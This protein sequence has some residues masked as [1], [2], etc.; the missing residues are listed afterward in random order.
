MLQRLPSLWVVS[1]KIKFLADKYNSLILCICELLTHFPFYG[2]DPLSV[3]FFS[4]IVS[5]QGIGRTHSP[6]PCIS[7]SRYSMNLKFAPK[8]FL[9]KFPD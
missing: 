1:F 7:A 8:I 5:A 3:H 9:V 2:T 6:T 4:I